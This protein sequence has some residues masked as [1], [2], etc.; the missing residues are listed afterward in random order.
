LTNDEI[1]RRI[2]SA[3]VMLSELKEADLQNGDLVELCAMASRLEFQISLLEAEL[4]AVE[5]V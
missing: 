5:R 3:K 1:S 2:A 4:K